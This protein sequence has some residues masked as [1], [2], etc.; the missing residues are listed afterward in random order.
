MNVLTHVALVSEPLGNV[1]NVVM[2]SIYSLLVNPLSVFQLV[3]KDTMKMTLIY[4]V[5]LVTNLVEPV[6]EKDPPLLTNVLFVM[7]TT[8]VKED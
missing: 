4:T 6:T 8:N 5:N 3:Q 7:L 1:M 2:V